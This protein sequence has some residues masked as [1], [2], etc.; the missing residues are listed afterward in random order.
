MVTLA[1]CR[2]LLGLRLDDA[3]SH[4]VGCMRARCLLRMQV[5][6]VGSE[7][8]APDI[9]LGNAVPDAMEGTLARHPSEQVT[10]SD[11]SL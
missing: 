10:S 11:L 3:C 8:I 4:V 6:P 5:E 7:P 9:Q 2:N 1:T